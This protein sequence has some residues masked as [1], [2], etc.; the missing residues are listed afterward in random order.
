MLSSPSG[1]KFRSKPQLARYIGDG[2]DLATFDFRTGKVNAML[3]RKSSKKH[4]SGTPYDFRWVIAVPTSD[5][6][7]KLGLFF[8]SSY[9]EPNAGRREALT[10]QNRGVRNDSSLVPPIRQ[11]ASIFK[12]PVSLY[13][14]QEG[15]VK[16]DFKHGA[17]EK[18]KQVGIPEIVLN[19]V[20]K[21]QRYYCSF[22]GRNG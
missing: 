12:Q 20:L 2:L 11:T 10:T 6:V 5:G 9:P 1:K 4:K 14:N 19:F 15:K 17:Q 13:K 16:S 3:S 18:P 8:S 21:I 22:S 7:N